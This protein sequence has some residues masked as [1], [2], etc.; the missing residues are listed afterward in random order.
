MGR[1][2]PD[3]LSDG[4][5]NSYYAGSSM[6]SLRFVRGEVQEIIQP[7]DPRNV[8]KIVPEYSVWANLYENGTYTSRILPHVV[9]CDLF[10]SGLSDTFTYTLRGANSTTKDTAGNKQIGD[11]LGSRVLMMAINGDRNNYVIISGIRSNKSTPDD[12]TL[13]HH[14]DFEFNGVSVNIN[15]D[16]EFT[17]TYGGAT[18]NDGTNRDD[19]DQS[20]TGTTIQITKDGSLSVTDQDAKESIV[21]DRPRGNLNVTASSGVAINAPQIKLGPAPNSPAVIGTAL[22]DILTQLISAISAI[23]V[24]TAGAPSSPP[25]NAPAFVAIQAQLNTIL[26][27]IITLQ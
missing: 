11:G 22:V 1:V 13:G 19:V 26:S 3:Y 12:P 4:N 6:S 5:N 2:I 20:A 15:N 17:L 14:L 23:V 7:N 18:K 21:I 9:A 24:T 8:N 16:G 10:G 25:V 27:T